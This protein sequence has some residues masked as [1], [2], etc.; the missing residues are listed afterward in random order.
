[1]LVGSFFHFLLKFSKKPPRWETEITVVTTNK[2]IIFKLGLVSK[3][4]FALI[5][6]LKLN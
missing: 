3:N 6:W 2:I 4:Y 1:M 5:G